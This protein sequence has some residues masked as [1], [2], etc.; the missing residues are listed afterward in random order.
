MKKIVLC[1]IYI[2]IALFGYTYNCFSFNNSRAVFT[3]SENK[4]I[5]ENFIIIPLDLT[6][7]T[8]PRLDNNGEACAL[9]KVRYAAKGVSFEG[10]IVGSCENKKG[11]YYVYMTSGSKRLV[12]KSLDFYPLDIDISAYFPKG[13]D[14]KK[15][16]L[17]TIVGEKE[18]RQNLLIDYSPNFA[19]VLVDNQLVNGT[20]G[21]VKLLLPVGAH[22]FIIAA[23]GYYSENGTINLP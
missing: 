18:K 15:T 13:L 3:A 14:G 9:I 6:A 12:V 20:K 2:F 10:N 4:S 1:F 23:D 8:K 5:I 7:S 22:E 17:L 16:Y 21:N 11:E 19:T